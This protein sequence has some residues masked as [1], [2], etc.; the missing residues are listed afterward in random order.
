MTEIECMCNFGMARF[1][2]LF[3][4]QPDRPLKVASRSNKLRY[5]S[6]FSASGLTGNDNDI[7]RGNLRS[8]ARFL[9][10]AWKLNSSS[11]YAADA[12]YVFSTDRLDPAP[13]GP[14]IRMVLKIKI[15]PQT[16]DQFGQIKIPACGSIF[17]SQLNEPGPQLRTILETSATHNLSAKI[18]VVALCSVREAQY[19]RS[20]HKARGFDRINLPPGGLSQAFKNCSLRCR[21]LPVI[22]EPCTNPIR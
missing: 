17:R 3:G 5:H 10:R 9:I 1:R 18:D 11:K 15:R 12:G 22:Q 2:E 21:W 19:P 13:V 20:R 14:E 16:R 7:V 6:R 8:H 4:A